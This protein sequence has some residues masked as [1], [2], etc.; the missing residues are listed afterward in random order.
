MPSVCFYFQVHQPNRLKPYSFFDL[1][2]DHFY[3]N[4]SLNT[5]IVSKVADKCYLPANKMMLKLIKQHKGKFKIAFSISGVA[6]EQF[7]YH[8]PDVLE[9]FKELA[10][11][12]HVEFL[13]ET[14]YHSLS[15]FYSKEEFRRQVKLHGKKIY[16]HFGQNPKVFRNTEL[17]YNNE[18]ARY[19]EVM[20]Y[21]GIITEGV[22]WLLHGRTPNVLFRA[23]RTDM[24]LLLRNHKL[25]DDI[26]FRF[27]DA[28]WEEYPLNAEK[29]ADWL[30]KSK[31]EIVNLFMDYESIGEHQWE[32][33]GIFDFF[34]ELPGK[35]IKNKKLNF[36]TPTQAV[37]K[38]RTWDTYDVHNP[39]SW[40]DFERDLSAWKGNTMQNEALKKVFQLEKLVKSSRNIDLIHV[41][42]KLQT[43][44]HFY[45]LS[46]KGHT[47]GMVH[48]YFSPY[49]S[50]YDGYIY[51][52]NALSDLEIMLN[53][54]SRSKLVA[55][56]A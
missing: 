16:Q 9:S 56:K 10:Q 22:D 35:V 31:G 54:R 46:T 50:P 37:A 33:T 30:D 4:D 36:I 8:R 15:F 28:N 25:S 5:E 13:A 40:A 21:K 34:N 3:E 27:S 24:K 2:H 41:W 51:Y 12:G 55:V 1:G 38:Y 6:I 39:I 48:S 18:M 29:F 14:Y 43:S 45:Y 53:K 7:E 42:S 20:G 32:S 47:D 11:T 19:L 44:D 26:G 17:C 23:P 49:N 52:M